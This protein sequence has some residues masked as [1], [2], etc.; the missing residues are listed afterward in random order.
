MNKP[1]II[2]GLIA[3]AVG[4]SLLI[5]PPGG[6]HALYEGKEMFHT[7]EEYKTFKL[8]MGQSGVE[9]QDLKMLSSEPPIVVAYSVT[10]DNDYIFP[11]GEKHTRRQESTEA[12]VMLGGLTLLCCGVGA[13][14]LG[15][16]YN[17]LT[18]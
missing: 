6:T 4:L 9:I 10:A 12:A 2:L 1:I 7:E 8:E 17:R 3:L 13:I 14:F 5:A 11:Y 18:Q 15:G 16:A